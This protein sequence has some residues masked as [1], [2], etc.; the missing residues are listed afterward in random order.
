MWWGRGK[1]VFYWTP[2]KRKIGEQSVD[3]TLQYLIYWQ[4]NLFK[5]VKDLS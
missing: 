1:G 2:L 5:E 4:E 3:N